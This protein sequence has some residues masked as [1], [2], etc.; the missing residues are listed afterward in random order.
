MSLKDKLFDALLISE[1]AFASAAGGA[2]S[3]YF[4]YSSRTPKKPKE[5]VRTVRSTLENSTLEKVVS[6]EVKDK[7]KDIL[8]YSIPFKTLHLQPTKYQITNQKGKK[9]DL[10]DFLQRSVTNESLRHYVKGLIKKVKKAHDNLRKQRIKVNDRI[11]A[12]LA[13]SIMRFDVVRNSDYTLDYEVN[14]DSRQTWEEF[15]KPKDKT[16]KKLGDC[17]DYSTALLSL[18]AAML[19]ETESSKDAFGKRLFDVLLHNQIIGLGYSGDSRYGDNDV[20]HEMLALLQ[21]SDDFR[22]VSLKLLEPQ[23]LSGYGNNKNYGLAF[24]D[25]KLVMWDS[26]GKKFINIR[27]LEYIYTPNGVYKPS[28]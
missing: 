16:K 20:G 27:N 3:T 7:R 12:E 1:I 4:I 11:L 6:L 17:D 18:Y 22:H 21:Y 25:G 2:V 5:I 23:K 26:R 28:K 24:A 9:E 10:K 15:Y 14:G 13:I 8:D 19:K